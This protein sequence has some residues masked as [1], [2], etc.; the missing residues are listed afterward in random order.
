MSS[1]AGVAYVLFLLYA[2]LRLLRRPATGATDFIVAGRRLTLP[3][4]TASL[5]STWYGGILG[6]GEYAWSYGISNWLVFGVPY[7]LFA[8]VFAVFLAG[9][10][11]RSRVLTVPDLLHE[12]YGRT[13]A[14]IGA[15]VI[16]VMTAP[17]A[18]VLMLGVLV[19]FV[20]GWPLW[21][22]VALGT[23][24]SVGYV[25]RGGLRAVVA[26]DIVQFFLM[27]A[28]FLI[29]VPA[30]VM[31]FGGWEFLRDGLP[32]GHLAWDGGL[33]WQAIAVWYFIAMSTLVEPAFY[34]RCYA[35][36]SEAT[37]RRG[38]SAAI[39]LWMVFD[40]LTTTAGLY[41]RALL[42]DLAD[43]VTA[44]PALAAYVLPAF[45]QGVFMVGLLAT[46]MST[47]DSYSF[48]G[49][50]TL[51]RDLIGRWRGGGARNPSLVAM[52]TGREPEIPGSDPSR[53]VVITTRTEIEDTPTALA[54]I[55]WSLLGTAILAIALAL[56]AGSVITLWKTLGSLGT[57]VLLLPLATAHS[58]LRLPPR[59]V[60]VSMLA[61][62]STAGGWLLLGHGGPWLGVEAIF[63]GLGMSLLVLGP[64]LLMGRRR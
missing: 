55:R 58:S 10:A 9:R 11:R 32:A 1:L 48:I 24:L 35:A 15:G 13:A 37:A 6:V 53:T 19:K 40:F 25:F 33:G 39:G 62:G 50:V 21:L 43:P 14:L 16:F 34:Q 7:Y 20:T 26:T 31:R 63:P 28:G 51:G 27:F 41:A 29:L 46:I 38:I 52:T 49:A 61:S 30:C 56:T 36:R 57:P 4:F 54:L 60:V 64:A 59:L 42:P 8:G 22:G 44:F 23:A 45:W 5:V 47:V 17:A 2:V 18:Y 3:A 12:R